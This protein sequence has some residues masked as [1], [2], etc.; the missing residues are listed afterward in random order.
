MFTIKKGLD[1]PISGAPPQQI[2]PGPAITSVAVIGPDYHGMKPTMMVKEGDTVALG[3][4]LFED[5]KN[6]KVFYT[7]PAAGT[8]SA[9][10][11]GEKR[12]LE[13]VVIDIDENGQELS[14]ESLG[15]SSLSGR[16]S[17][18]AIASRSTVR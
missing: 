3:Q 10:N 12:V 17:R 14:W 5:K 8:V 11:R 7:A 9:I 6:P 18:P 16:Y 2:L 13:S 4:K 1:V 15:K